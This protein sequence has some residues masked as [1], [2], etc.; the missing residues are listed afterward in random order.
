MAA[1]DRSGVKTKWAEMHCGCRYAKTETGCSS[2]SSFESMA[3]TLKPSEYGIHT[4]RETYCISCCPSV[5]KATEL[6]CTVVQSSMWLWLCPSSAFHERNYPGD[7][8]IVS[9]FGLKET[10]LDAVGVESFQRQL[11]LNMLAAGLQ[12]KANIESWRSTNIW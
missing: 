10:D 4:D 1:I 5:S 11:Y 7:P 6:R 2:L 9:Y 12:R 3:A 8:L